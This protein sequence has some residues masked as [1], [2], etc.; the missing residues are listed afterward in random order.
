[1]IQYVIAR[2]VVTKQSLELVV[3]NEDGE[4]A[5]ASFGWPRNDMEKTAESQ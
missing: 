4:I 2:N 3:M 5:T 1:M